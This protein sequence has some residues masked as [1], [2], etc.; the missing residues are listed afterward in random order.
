MC[1][2]FLFWKK[3]VHRWALQICSLSSELFKYNFF[4]LVSEVSFNDSQVND[5]MGFIILINQASQSFHLA[6]SQLGRKGGLMQGDGQGH[7]DSARG[8]RRA[9]QNAGGRAHG[10]HGSADKHICHV[11]SQFA[12]P[13]WKG[14]KKKNLKKKP[15]PLKKRL[16]GAI[17]PKVK[18]NMQSSMRSGVLPHDL[19]RLYASWGVSM[20]SRNA[21]ILILSIF[22][23]ETGCCLDSHLKY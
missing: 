8:C 19:S 10:E 7:C 14:L 22:S 2:F 3:Y 9:H 18:G 4:F 11:S 12:V 6:L 1:S 15:Q 13:W 21:F 17:F 20:V 16:S 23:S 5:D